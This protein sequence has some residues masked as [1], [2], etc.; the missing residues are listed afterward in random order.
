MIMRTLLAFLLGSTCFLGVLPGANAQGRE[1]RIDRTNQIFAEWDRVD[2]PGCAVG[3]VRDGELA[4]ERGYGSA[5][6]DY[7]VPLTSQSVF[8]MAST[9]KQFAAASIALLALRGEL[10]LEDEVSKYIPEFPTYETPITI[11][12]LIHH[13][14]GVRDYLGLRSIAGRDFEDFFDMAWA[15]ELISR[16]ED[17]NFEPGSE[18]LYSNSGYLLLAEIVGR[19]TGQPLAEFGRENFFAPLGM[20]ATHWGDDRHRVVANRVTSYDERSDGTQRRYLKNFHAM[21][22]GNLLSSVADLVQWD[23]MFY[24]TT[25]TWLPLVELMHT[26]GVLNDGTTLDYA[27]G[28]FAGEY[29]DRRTISHGGAFLGFRTE[30]LRFPDD[31]F[32]SIVLCNFGA[33]NP[34]TY[35]QQVADVWLFDEVDSVAELSPAADAVEAPR[36]ELP[37]SAMASLAG[38]Y[39]T[40]DVPLGDVVVSLG[41]AVLLLEAAGE[42]FTLVP[43]APQSFRS[44]DGPTPLRVRFGTEDGRTTLRLFLPGDQE[45]LLTESEEV[46]P[47]TPTDLGAFVGSFYSV[48]V[49][50]TYLVFQRDGQL[51]VE[52]RGSDDAVLRPMSESKFAVGGSTL[53][54]T[55]NSDGRVDGFSLDAGRVRG[56]RFVRQ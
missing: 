26:P 6:L 8:Y 28:L 45:I 50:A 49:D 9:S 48:E 39:R 46:E 51:F 15:V 40:P 33:A 20:P 47:P 29:R 12:H 14:S 19:V 56:L 22:D 5:N 42:T 21:G 7:N 36:I 11:R 35:A 30:L 16:Q 23:R 41:D 44:V 31:G 1:A 52:R 3:V 32:T 13:T 4:F 55:R 34:T 18:F 2:S 25:D 37:P 24:D 53:T 54:F 38:T 17:L 27:F 10:S 43:T